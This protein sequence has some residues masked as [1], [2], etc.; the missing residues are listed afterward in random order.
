MAIQEAH[1]NPG[2]KLKIPNYTTH[3]TDRLTHRGGGTALLIRN[4]I[5]HHTTPIAS[6]TFENTTISINLPSRPQITVSI[7]YRPPHETSPPL[8]LTIFSIQAANLLQCRLQKCPM[9]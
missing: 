6:S 1:L 2:D 7:I 3:R 4:S 8:N 5:D 9:I